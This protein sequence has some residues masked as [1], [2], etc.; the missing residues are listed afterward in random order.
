M[1]KEPHT[2]TSYD[3]YLHIMSSNGAIMGQPENIAAAR[4]YD[5]NISI[6]FVGSPLP[7]FPSLHD[8]NIYLMY[9]NNAFQ[10]DS[11]IT[12]PAAPADQQRPSTPESSNQQGIV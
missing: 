1:H 3:D 12:V 10:Y 2:Y 9:G 5:N 11:R 6:T 8:N 7:N 4:L